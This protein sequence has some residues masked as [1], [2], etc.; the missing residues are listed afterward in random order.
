M[1]RRHHARACRLLGAAKNNH[2]QSFGK[3]SRWLRTPCCARTSSYFAWLRLAFAQHV[4]FMTSKV[5]PQQNQA[6]DSQLPIRPRAIAWQNCSNREIM[7]YFTTQPCRAN[8]A[9][10]RLNCGY[11]S[12][13]II[14]LFWNI[15]GALERGR[16]LH[17][18]P[19]TNEE[20]LDGSCVYPPCTSLQRFHRFCSVCRNVE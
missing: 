4:N 18:D 17:N 8:R 9:N 15:L 6:R 5:S 7:T 11:L 20:L 1:I 19:K 14:G 3:K 16:R 10:H 2:S 13:M 12:V